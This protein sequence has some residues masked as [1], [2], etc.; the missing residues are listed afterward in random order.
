MT[1][2][3]KA[4]FRISSAYKLLAE[5]V[6]KLKREYKED[7]FKQAYYKLSMSI[8]GD[9][10]NQSAMLSS[11]YY[12]TRVSLSQISL[13]TCSYH[14][15]SDVGYND[16]TVELNYNEASDVLGMLYKQFLSMQDFSGNCIGINKDSYIFM[17]NI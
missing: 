11:W 10:L 14:L 9:M 5:E 3:N 7:E 13:N 1:N 2:L 4:K 6:K 16:I 15:E 8:L 12:T 17:M